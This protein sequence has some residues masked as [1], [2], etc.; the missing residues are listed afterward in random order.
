MLSAR[1]Q[2]IR[3]SVDLRGIH[4]TEADIRAYEE[5]PEL[6]NH[7]IDEWIEDPRFVDRMKEIFNL[8]FFSRN[9]MTYFDPEVAG[10]FGIDDRDMADYIAEESLQLLRYIIENELPYSYIV[11]ADHTMANAPLASMW[12]MD[13]PDGASGWQISH[14]T[15]GRPEA[16]MLT[17]TGIWR[18]YPSMGGNANR[19]RA[20]AISKMFLCDDYLSRP[21]VLN[22]AAVDQLTVDPEDAINQND[23]CQGC[24]S[25]LDPMSANFF[26]FF[27]YADDD[28]IEQIVYRPEFEEEWREYS[29]KPPG[30]Y[31]RPTANIQEFSQMLASDQ[32]FAD[33][34]VR[35]VF[36]G[37]TQRTTTEEDWTE[38]SNHVAAFQDQDQNIKA[39]VRSIVLAPEYTALSSDDASLN[40]RITGVKTASPEQLASIIEDATGYRWAFGG[41]DGLTTSDLGLPVLS[42][43]IDSQFVTTPSYVP[44]VG[45]AFTVERLSQSAA[46]SVADHDL[47]PERE[48][49]ARLLVYVTVNDTPDNNPDA[50]KTQIRH[51]YTAVTGTPLPDDA[52]EPDELIALWKYLYSV[53]ASAPQAWAGILSAVLR[54]PR[55]IFY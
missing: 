3:L 32:R 18:R 33:C 16:G 5:A 22:R 41:R 42:G 48:G 54:D 44:S 12:D 26:G 10:V 31:G 55:V 14:Y 2:L 6:W 20:N 43:G 21:I 50:F 40:D 35:T 19:H 17:M 29:G 28:D 52:T 34:A 53:E 49:D 11:T 51:L 15:D 45:T 24:H 1:A 7:Y 4:P 8:R 27:N 9:G 47:N 39:L 36:E 13:Y 25:T 38:L 37:L 46:W 30:Y 23:G